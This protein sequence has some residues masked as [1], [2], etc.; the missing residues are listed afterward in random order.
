[1]RHR[2]GALLRRLGSSTKTSLAAV[3]LGTTVYLSNDLIQYRKLK[4]N[5]KNNVKNVLVLPFHRM[6]I[7]EHKK[8]SPF[9]KL[10]SLSSGDKMMEVE[11]HELVDM[12]H[13]AANDPSIHSIY[14]TFGHGFGFKC[15]GF[16]HIEEIR[17]AIRVFNESHRR[18]KN[19]R[20][21]RNEE[22][23]SPIIKR[24]YAFA[25]TFDNPIDSANKEYFL[26]SA[27]SQIYLQPRGNI[28]LYGVSLQNIF[29]ADSFKKYGLKASVFRHGIYKNAGSIFTDNAYTKAHL[30]NSRAIAQS[31]NNVMYEKISESRRFPKEFNRLWQAVHDYGT[32]SADNAQEIGLVD[33]LPQV[34]PL[35]DLV[36]IS[37]GDGENLNVLKTK[38][39]ALTGTFDGNKLIDFSSYKQLLLK[40]KA[41]DEQKTKL[42][43]TLKHMK[44]R[45]TAFEGLVRAFGYDPKYFGFDKES[46]DTIYSKPTT[47]KIAVIHVN[48]TIRDKTAKQVSRALREIKDDKTVK[49][50]IL[51]ID[52]P[53]GAV[54]ASET[55]LEECK[56][57]DKPIICSFSNLA[58]SGGYYISTH[59]DK[60]FSSPTTLTGSIG[61]L[62]LKFD[63]TEF[64]KR[65]GINAGF[66][67]SSSHAQTFNL[68]Q[69]LT[70][71]TRRNLERF[72]DR[73][74]WYFKKI[75]AEGRNLST[76][77]VNQVA[78]GRV[79]TGIQAKEI[80]LVDELGG[81]D[82]ALNYAK[83]KY[84]SE[85]A[86]VLTYPKQK[87]LGETLFKIRDYD[88][89][90]SESIQ[91]FILSDLMK[92][93][94]TGFEDL[95]QVSVLSQNHVTLCMDEKSAVE[96]ILQEAF[97]GDL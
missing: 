26:A 56:D 38:W 52:S 81:F 5:K 1:M 75:V 72:V 83:D 24:S 85:N 82:R 11:I 92:S 2:L 91:N 41:W 84:A 88:M 50:I 7:V 16:A 68:L 86:Q 6:K 22:I 49:C 31:I 96:M 47:D 93:I 69:P 67:S 95:G 94:V 14:A 63:A 42:Y 36:K 59:A 79:W 40:Q 89:T 19:G 78:Q 46:V 90:Q 66:V 30:E 64:A 76:K 77:E 10:S 33:Q 55:I 20:G 32:M 23:E 62:S 9:S 25:D 37:S 17:D 71:E 18:H 3:G 45:S 48:G 87:S 35:Y 60:I 15:G 70:K 39:S 27:F 29:L 61:V 28:H 12:I 97:Y 21:E 54:T 65:H 57:S 51:R 4:G 74:Y 43:Q 80:G 73:V 13:N 8:S 44:D 53:G 34:N 58:A